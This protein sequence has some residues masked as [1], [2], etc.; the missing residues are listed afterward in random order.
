MRLNKQMLEEFRYS[1]F[2]K[3]AEGLEP[4]TTIP[5]SEEDNESLVKILE[6]IDEHGDVE[7]VSTNAT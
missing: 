4:K 2:E 3:G 5:L 1:Q 7:S 6:Q